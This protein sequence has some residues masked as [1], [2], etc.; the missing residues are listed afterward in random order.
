MNQVSEE[1]KATLKDMQEKFEYFLKKYQGFGI[2]IEQC[3]FYDGT[4]VRIEPK[5][6]LCK[7]NKVEVKK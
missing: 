5:M 7:V 2:V 4:G 1:D 3:A 6:M